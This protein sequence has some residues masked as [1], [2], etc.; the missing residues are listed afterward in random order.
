VLVF[1]ALRD[2]PA[3]EEVTHSYLERERW[4]SRTQ[5]QDTLRVARGFVCGCKE[6]SS[7]VRG[8]G[9][10]S[11]GSDSGGDRI[12][13]NAQ[14]PDRKRVFACAGCGRCASVVVVVEDEDEASEQCGQKPRQ[15]LRCS[16]CGAVLARRECKQMLQLEVLLFTPTGYVK[17][18]VIV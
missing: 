8:S 11:G 14:T 18:Y 3:G 5:R 2:I 15:Q 17:V 12:E 9:G 7:G 13:S 4:Y 6:C 1:T 16:E 10:D